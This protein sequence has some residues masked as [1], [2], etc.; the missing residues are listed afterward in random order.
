MYLLNPARTALV[1]VL[2]AGELVDGQ[3]D[4]F[5]GGVVDVD[6]GDVAPPPPPPP[7][8][9]RAYYEEPYEGGVWT[10]S[11]RDGVT[12]SA[13]GAADTKSLTTQLDPK[14]SGQVVTIGAVI[15]YGADWNLAVNY[16]HPPYRAVPVTDKAN[17]TTYLTVEAPVDFH[18]PGPPPPATGSDYGDRWATFLS[19]DGRSAVDLFGTTPVY[20]SSGQ[21]VRIWTKIPPMRSDLTGDG[22][23]SN[24]DGINRAY[25]TL[26]HRASR[27]P[28]LAGTNRK[29]DV[30]RRVFRHAGLITLPDGALKAG[31]IWPALGQDANASTMYSGNVPMG[32]LVGIEP[33]VDVN[34]VCTSDVGRAFAE[35]QVKRFGLRV[36]DRSKTRAL[37]CERPNPADP[38]YDAYVTQLKLLAA[39]WAR[40]G[41]YLRVIKGTTPELPGGPGAQRWD[42]AP[43][44]TVVAP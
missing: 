37:A 18:V 36:G 10:T 6:E 42:D 29:V 15:N 32:S 8:S 31:Y 14:G 24:T 1:E 19:A 44:G 11:L 35:Q 4:L 27:W 34:A 20:N 3:L 5:D 22:L 23:R 43:A 12:Y 33:N 16:R 40:L 2:G 7:P 21:L 41:P 39:D 28:Y 9:F 13:P 17:T 26:S 38:D 30:M 25:S